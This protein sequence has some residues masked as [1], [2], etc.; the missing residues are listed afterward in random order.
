M[1]SERVRSVAQRR[2]PPSSP[3][4]CRARSLPQRPRCRRRATTPPFGAASRAMEAAGFGHEELEA[5]AAAESAPTT[6]SH[7]RSSCGAR[8]SGPWPSLPAARTVSRI[9]R[10]GRLATSHWSAAADSTLQIGAGLELLDDR[11]GQVAMDHAGIAAS[12]PRCAGHC[13][14]STT[15]PPSGSR[16]CGITSKGRYSSSP[17]FHAGVSEPCQAPARRR[18]KVRRAAGPMSPSRSA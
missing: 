9:S 15:N 11:G 3:S 16:R 4:V 14:P 13:W 12:D 5:D 17:P 6:P 1:V 8:R 10:Q 2:P 7:V 18:A